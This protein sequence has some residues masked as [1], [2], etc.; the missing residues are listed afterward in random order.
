MQ[1]RTKIDIAK[2]K[3]GP[4]ADGIVGLINTNVMNLLSQLQQLSLKIGPTNQVTSS[5]PSLAQPSSINAIQSSNPKEN[6]N[7]NGKKEGQGKKKSQDGEA[8]TNK[9]GNS[10]GEGGKQSKKKIKFPLQVMQWRPFDSSLLQNSRF[11]VLVSVAR[12]FYLSRYVN[13]PFSRRVAASC[14]RELKSW[15]LCR[16]QLGRG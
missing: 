1:A 12:V 8:D 5:N 6:Q 2:C 7:S 3:L 16:G 11:S 4:H 13:Q 15:Y 14:W 10:A 9:P